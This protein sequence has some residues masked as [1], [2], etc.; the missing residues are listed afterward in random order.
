MS[1]HGPA[2]SAYQIGVPPEC[3]ISPARVTMGQAPIGEDT[4]VTSMED[5][6]SITLPDAGVV[7]QACLL[8][9]KRS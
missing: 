1:P 3:V 4:A 9:C 7:T 6:R 5:T 8:S 2:T